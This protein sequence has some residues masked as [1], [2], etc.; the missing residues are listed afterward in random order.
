MLI[1]DDITFKHG[2]CLKNER[3]IA[4]HSLLLISLQKQQNQIISM[5]NYF[6][7]RLKD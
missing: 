4:L 1:R 3:I 5:I 2:K 7:L 6:L